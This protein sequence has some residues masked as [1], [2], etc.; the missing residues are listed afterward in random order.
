ME[1]ANKTI[2]KLRKETERF[3]YEKS[4]MIEENKVIKNARETMKVDFE[5]RLKEKDHVIKSKVESIKLVKI[6]IDASN[7]LIKDLRM[8]NTNIIEKQA[9]VLSKLEEIN[10]VAETLRK[11]NETIIK[12]K[13]SVNDD[14]HTQKHIYD[15]LENTFKSMKKDSDKR[16]KEKDQMLE[17]ER[18]SKTNMKKEVDN[19]RQIIKTL[20]VENKSIMKLMTENDEKLSQLQEEIQKNQKNLEK[21]F[22][23]IKLRDLAIQKISTQ[24]RL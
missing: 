5:E 4:L 22:Q 24:K 6:E 13:N 23:E 16:R 11:T 14:L 8:T 21:S 15:I 3:K 9:D 18:E 12:E 17:N 2:E 20:Q 1:D 19:S 7:A 10:Q